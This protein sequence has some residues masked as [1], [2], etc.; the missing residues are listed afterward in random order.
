ME[1]MGGFRHNREP[2]EKRLLW[3]RSMNEENTECQKIKPVK[4]YTHLMELIDNLPYIVMTLL[5]AAVLFLCIQT[6]PGRWI[7]A[8]SYMAYGLAGA[9]WIILF[10]CPYCHFFD[11]RSC[12]CGYGQISAK[13]RKVQDQSLFKKKFKIHIPVIVP[14]WVIPPVVGIIRLTKDFTGLLFIV[15]VLFAVDAFIVLP[16]VSRIYGCAHCPQKDA[17]PWMKTQDQSGQN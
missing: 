13:I 6:A 1:L 5:G 9:M 15:S 2:I 7:I 11:T 12:P 10:V 4:D 3:N 16:L 14:L 8:G 17:C